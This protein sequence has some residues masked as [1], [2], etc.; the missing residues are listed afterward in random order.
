MSGDEGLFD[1]L[2]VGLTVAMIQT[3]R[4]D[5]V[6][7]LS[8]DDANEVV[9]RNDRREEKYDYLPVEND[10][11]AIVGLFQATHPAAVPSLAGTLVSSRMDPLSDINLVGEEASILDFIKTIDT[12]PY[13]LVVA[14]PGIAG[15]V[16]WSDLQKSPVRVALFGLITGLEIEMA[17]AIRR[18]YRTMDPMEPEW[19]RHLDGKEGRKLRGRIR[20]SRE[21]D[22][23]VD[24]LV[25]TDIC[26]KATI[27][28]AI[29]CPEPW[30]DTARKD[31][32]G[33]IKNLRNRVAHARD[34]ATSREE[35]DHVCR[36]ARNLV[37]IRE[38]VVQWRPGCEHR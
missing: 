7:C 16:T 30:V 11:G 35:A 22:S 5:L 12:K 26:H 32:F 37:R 1:A 31:E 18:R 23:E 15:I 27:L 4:D 10:S 25:Y 24:A 28:S 13:R 3:G 14:G 2:H 9:S 17:G 34:Y 20:N 33:E 29:H 19:M 21:N 36:V 38:E 8:E 6:T